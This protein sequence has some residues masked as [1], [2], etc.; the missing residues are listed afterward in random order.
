M[1]NLPAR[2]ALTVCRCL[3]D[4]A[5][6]MP[7]RL[8]TLLRNVGAPG[9]ACDVQAQGCRNLTFLLPGTHSGTP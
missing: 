8:A 1:S 7:V 2:P 3:L 4:T 5:A 9:N 6:A